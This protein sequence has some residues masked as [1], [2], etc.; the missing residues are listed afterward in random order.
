[1]N[2]Q[3]LQKL[4]L[5]DYP[6]HVACTLFTAGCQ[7]D[8]PFCHNSELITGPFGPGE[9]EESIFAFLR[10]RQGLLDGICVSGGEPL[11]QPDIEAFLERVKALGYQVKLDTNG[12][13]PEKLARLI[14]AGLVDYVAMDIKNTP[15]RYA[16][17]CGVTDLDLT[18]YI[19][20]RELL[21]EGRTDYEFR[22]T[23]VKEF[24]SFE[25]MREIAGWL[26]GAKRYYLQSFVDRDQVRDHSLSAHNEATLQKMLEVVKQVLPCAELR[27]I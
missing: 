20:S 6:E 27:G 1:M 19:R 2:I 3:G 23:I 9:T 24:H 12:G 18:P 22:T 10:K 4:T 26:K 25:D 15:A 13:F 17:T 21:L 8:C 11:L 7:L 14:E 5:L 16:E